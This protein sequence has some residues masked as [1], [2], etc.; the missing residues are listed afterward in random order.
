VR[1]RFDQ[2]R[3]EIE[4][5]L[6]SGQRP[7]VQRAAPTTLPFFEGLKPEIAAGDYSAFWSDDG[8]RRPASVHLKLSGIDA[9]KG[10]YRIVVSNPLRQSQQ[11]AVP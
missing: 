11:A 7:I 5:Y 8:R 10:F 4:R 1:Q 6:P 2:V 9:R 3:R